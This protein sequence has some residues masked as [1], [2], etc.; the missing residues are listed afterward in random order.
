MNK[1]TFIQHTKKNYKLDFE[2]LWQESILAK[3]E[4]NVQRALD[5]NIEKSFWKGLAPKYDDTA[6][7]Y[8]YAP[9]TFHKLL[10]II[11]K[12]K[13]LAEIGPGTGK[14][15]LPMSAYAKKILAIDASESMLKMLD[16]KIYENNILN[17]TPICSK[18][19][20]ASIEKIDAIFNVNAIYRM[21][22][23]KDCLMKMNNL[24]KEK[25][26]IVWTLQRSPFHSIFCK[27]G[28]P[29]LKT[30]SDY[31]YIQNLLYELGIDANI[32]FLDIIKPITYANTEDLY[33]DFIEQ[34]DKGILPMNK[35]KELLNCQIIKH[36]DS[37]TFNAKL[38]VAYIYWNTSN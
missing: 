22:N 15:T 16:K 25:V 32:E 5:F 13:V 23:I 36:E 19:E 35:V 7:L 12:D 31:I 37:I 38:K 30:L 28:Q 3:D 34:Y 14:F 6:T 10:Q 20:D 33:T 21:W 9:E 2:K 4:Y 17:V 8:D 29:G 18:W 11:G 27:L 26:V 1:S 24:A